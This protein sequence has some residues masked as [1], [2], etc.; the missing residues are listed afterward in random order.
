MAYWT[1]SV[2]RDPPKPTLR[3]AYPEKSCC[4]LFQSRNQKSNSDK[5]SIIWASLDPFDHQ[6]DFAIVIAEANPH[7]TLMAD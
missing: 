4:R 5:L 1:Q 3:T 6:G 2:K 7:Q